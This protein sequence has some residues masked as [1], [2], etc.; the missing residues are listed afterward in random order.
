MVSGEQMRKKSN[1]G[2][3]KQL[4]YSIRKINSEIRETAKRGYT[5]CRTTIGF[6]FSDDDIKTI[7]K[8]Y[9]SLGYKIKIDVTWCDV[10]VEW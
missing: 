10:S 7:E 9:T 3:A 5:S 6:C 8:Y 2:V 1:K 4:K